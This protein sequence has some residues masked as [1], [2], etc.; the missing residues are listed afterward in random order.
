[1]PRAILLCILLVSIS[2]ITEVFAQTIQGKVVNQNI[3]GIGYSVITLHQINGKDTLYIRYAK[4]NPDG[5][6]TLSITGVKSQECLLQIRAM[7]Y[8]S[9]TIP[10]NSFQQQITLNSKTTQLK[11]VVISRSV[12][13]LTI[14]GDTLEFDARA[15]GNGTERSVEDIL[16]RIPG[17]QVESDGRITFN[18]KPISKVYLD[19]Q[20]LFSQNYTLITRNVAA[21]LIDKVQAIEH[22]TENQLLRGIEK[23][24]Q[25]VLNLSVKTDRKT[26]LIGNLR[27]EAGT[28]SRGSINGSLF[29][30]KGRLKAGLIGSA[31]NTGRELS[32]LG[33]T[34]Y[35]Q[36]TESS[37]A[38]IQALLPEPPINRD[39]L[40][41]MYPNEV[42]QRRFVFNGGALGGIDMNL[43]ANKELKLKIEGNSW[44]DKRRA[45]NNFKSVYSLPD[46]TLEFSD[47]TKQ[48]EKPRQWN[49]RVR[50]DYTPG[51]KNSIRWIFDGKE[52]DIIRHQ[53]LRTI[54][55]QLSEQVDLKSNDLYKYYANELEWVHKLNKQNALV[56]DTRFVQGFQTIHTIFKSERYARFLGLDPV[57]YSPL[58]H[59]NN[60]SDKQLQTSIHWK[61]SGG[62]NPL[63]NAPAT[64]L[65]IG[66]ESHFQTQTVNSIYQLSNHLLADSL[67]PNRAQF[68][69]CIL[70]PGVD[71]KHHYVS[72]LETNVQLSFPWYQVTMQDYE[73]QGYVQ[74]SRVVPNARLSF[75]KHFQNKYT[76]RIGL[77]F[78]RKLQLPSFTS[79]LKG[80]QIDNY[81][82]FLSG[83]ETFRP[84]E[85]L[86]GTLRL[87]HNRINSYFTAIG[88][89]HYQVTKG[90]TAPAYQITD[91]LTFRTLVPFQS[92]I[93]LWQ[94][95]GTIDKFF[96]GT[97]L[98][99][100]I[101]SNFITTEF[102][103][104][105]NTQ[106]IFL[107]QPFRSFSGAAY[108]ISAF[109]LPV[110]AEVSLKVRTMTTEVSNGE[111]QNNYLYQPRILLTGKIKQNWVFQAWSE[112][113]L[114]RS[115]TS[116]A[117]FY[118]MDAS[119]IYT[120]QGKQWEIELILQNVLNTAYYFTT[121][122]NPITS[123]E[124][125]YKL[126]PQYLAI[127]GNIRF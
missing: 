41:M 35:Y 33:A 105:V 92:S 59:N 12:S 13:P 119:C 69:Q 11:E 112:V 79:L 44:Q 108:L 66:A 9:K 85:I 25:T 124:N 70:I 116:K 10:L 73:R 83:I 48:M 125:S 38:S 81:R 62:V 123:T 74:S 111:K 7:G 21:D 86:S 95:N 107:L 31:N 27:V 1:M 104:R 53:N 36:D 4:S 20:E 113:L 2:V 32:P 61:Y 106:D 94:I 71:L 76:Y 117:D 16:K 45:E 115:T 120:P 56:F 40:S 80:Y 30:L 126:Q 102:P 121:S 34:V 90:G 87:I 42:D 3:K 96:T 18:N 93:K 101:Q 24:N 49:V 28:F 67:W 65:K 103:T 110:N 82:S 89:I 68:Q 97:Q 91:L 98:K 118:L 15:F 122:V 84:T 39:G 26:R 57:I 51:N 109:D 100:K 60:Q 99:L 50:A 63:N 46:E 78:E 22:H 29:S 19:G 14:K 58:T 17:L 75:F 47:S 127:R 64:F 43:Q 23:S 77:D 114:W 88:M 8:E 72:N 5:I 52:Q 6:F 55:R 37:F 54:N